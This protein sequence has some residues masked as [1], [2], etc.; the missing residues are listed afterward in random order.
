MS[1]DLPDDVARYIEEQQEGLLSLIE[2]LCGIPAPSHQ[3]EERARFIATWLEDRGAEGVYVDEALNVVLPFGAQHGND[4]VLFM[5]HTDTV[6]PDTAPMPFYEK[7]GKLYSP[8]VGDNTANVAVLMLIAQYIL[9][10]KPEPAC[11]V[12]FAFNSC[13]EGLGNL[14]GCRQLMADYAG[15]VKQVV[16]FD[17]T[18]ANITSDA[19]GSTRYRVEVKTEGGH[20]Y[21]AFGNRNAIHLLSSMIGT[22]YD[23]KVP[24]QGKTTYNVGGISG[25]TS[26]NTIAQEAEM[27]YEYR[28]DSR[29]SLLAMERFFLGVVESY[30]NMG[31]E[32]SVE[33]LGE[34]PCSA[35]VDETAQEA[36]LGRCS[37]IIQHFSGKT[38]PRRPGSTDCNIPL[39]MGIPATCFGAYLGD[40]AHTREEWLSVDS[41]STGMSIATRLVLDYFHMAYL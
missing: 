10:R 29:N 3:E 13:E 14:K 5:A 24:H 41:L 19:V 12:L 31:I 37:G 16:S 27:L 22:L 1:Y 17:G 8:G 33:V 2:T 25:G 28:S 38:P 7:D 11:G 32:V 9:E 21:S 35:A 4:V 20:S 18:Y 36:L 30:R 6:F 39:S 26:V 34:R 15:R 23:M 40:G